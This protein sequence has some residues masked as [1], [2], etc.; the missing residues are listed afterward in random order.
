MKIITNLNLE[1][2]P[3]IRSTKITGYL[4]VGYSIFPCVLKGP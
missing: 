1:N 3:D 4:S 2:Q